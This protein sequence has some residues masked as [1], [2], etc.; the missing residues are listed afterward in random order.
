MK[1][2]ASSYIPVDTTRRLKTQAIRVW[3]VT[4][5]VAAIWVGLI[6]SAPLLPG[7]QFSPP[8][9]DFFSYICH[10]ISERSLHV[11]GHPMAVCSRCFGVY[12]GLLAGVLTYPV[13]RSID[14]TEPIARVWLFLSLIPITID[15]SLTVFGVWEN[16]HVSRFVTGMILGFACAIFIV[17]ALVEVVRNLSFKRLGT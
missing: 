15:W 4:G 10:Q 6:V 17:P 3:I 13:W 16:T 12:F 1:E 5:A 14:E 2:P 11:G 7:S 9:Y 8:I